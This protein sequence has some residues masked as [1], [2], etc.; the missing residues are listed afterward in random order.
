[1]RKSRQKRIE[2]TKEAIQ[3]FIDAGLANDYQV[4]FMNDMLVRLERGKGMSS[5]QRTWL[6][7]LH[8]DGP[9][10]PKGDPA[11]IARIDDALKT[12]V[13]DQRALSLIHI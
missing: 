3:A 10:A 1:M 6:D 11:L 8:A 2:D 4:R 9:P 7:S 13:K 5:K 12:L